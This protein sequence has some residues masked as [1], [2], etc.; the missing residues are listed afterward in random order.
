MF[1]SFKTEKIM[2]INRALEK[3]LADRDIRKSNNQQLKKS[4]EFV[5]GIYKIV[6]HFFSN[7]WFFSCI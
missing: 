4:C 2:F 5:L 6:F 3:I 7:N 1:E